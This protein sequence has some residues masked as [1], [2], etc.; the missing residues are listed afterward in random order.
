MECPSCGASVTEGKRFC[1]DCGAPIPIL[2]TACGSVNRPGARF[3]GDCG[4]SFTP[5]TSGPAA[6]R[7]GRPGTPAPGRV[8]REAERRQLTVMF[9]D[10]VGST[11]LAGRLDPEDMREVIRAYRECCVERVARFDGHV[12]QYLGDGLLVY[13]GYPHAHEDNVE[14]A[15]RAGLAIVEAVG[16]LK[17]ESERLLQVRVGIATG[18]MVVGDLIGHGAAQEEAV[19]GETPNLAARLQALAEPDSVVIAASTRRLIGG[20]F[21]CADLGIR[22]VKGFAEPVQAWRVVAET[23]A[24]SRFEAQHTAGLM[25]LVGR[26]REIALLFDCWRQAKAGEG[27]VVLL[28]GEPGIGKSRILRA[29]RDRVGDEPHSRLRYSCSPYHQTSALYPFIE[30]LERAAGVARDDASDR[31]LDKLEALL[32]Q[33][34]VSVESV[35]PL[36]AA[37]LSIPTGGR[38]PPLAMSLGQAGL[39]Q[40]QPPVDVPRQDEPLLLEVV[41]VLSGRHARVR[42]LFRGHVGAGERGVGGVGAAVP[43]KNHSL[44]GALRS[45]S[46]RGMRTG[47]RVPAFVRV[48]TVSYV[49][50]RYR[51]ASC[52]ESS[53]TGASGLRSGQG[54][55]A[56]RASALP[57][58]PLV[59]RGSAGGFTPVSP[60]GGFRGRPRGPRSRRAAAARGRSTG[61]LSPDS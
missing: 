22:H 17:P 46:P 42:P 3:C 13:F 25:P 20:L 12:A 43:R 7:P 53:R 48:S 60:R 50:P 32:A 23:P 16:R 27:Q 30:Q 14:R 40:M 28:S 45:R 11:A 39:V 15:V 29:L 55:E 36:V 34:A 37:L 6:A 26:D 8:A 1:S 49:I 35:T 57:S 19:V 54:A 59:A 10:L 52:A 58:S 47:R 2:C 41:R 56:I 31:K 24:D 38:Y 44:V 61:D 4:A 5:G 9:C 33:G 51:A 21:E 18:L